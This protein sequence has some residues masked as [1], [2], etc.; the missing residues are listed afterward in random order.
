MPF[1]RRLESLVWV[2]GGEG[3]PGTPSRVHPVY[4]TDRTLKAV[5]G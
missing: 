2:V 1:S 4:V 3:D 5:P